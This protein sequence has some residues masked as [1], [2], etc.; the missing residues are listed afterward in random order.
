MMLLNP[1][2]YKYKRYKQSR[3]EIGDSGVIHIA[4]PLRENFCTLLIKDFSTADA[5][6]EFLGCNIGQRIGV[7]TPRAWLFNND[8]GYVNSKINFSCAVGI[9]YLDGLDDEDVRP[10]ETEATTIQAVQGKFL[11]II[12]GEEDGKAIARHNGRIYAIDFAECMF[13]GLWGNEVSDVLREMPG[14]KGFTLYER[15]LFEQEVDPYKEMRSEIHWLLKKGVSKETITAVYS[16]IRE[17][18]MKCY[19]GNEFDDLVREI[20]ESFTEYAARYA[21]DLLRATYNM[22][23]DIPTTEGEYFQTKDGVIVMTNKK[24]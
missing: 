5:I 23:V 6:N 15:E 16:D 24:E 21:K 9:E 11:H 18:Y 2:E 1:M 19:N 22:I 7:N 12:L 13:S 4:R 14:Q 3:K 10:F 17:K 20:G 8:K